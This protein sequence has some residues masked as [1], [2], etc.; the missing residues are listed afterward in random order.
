MASGPSGSASGTVSTLT[1]GGPPV[2][3]SPGIARVRNPIWGVNVR[4][5]LLC[6][7]VL[8]LVSVVISVPPQAL[9]GDPARAI[10][11]RTGTPASR[12]A[13]G[14]QLHLNRPLVVQY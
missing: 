5:L 13:L 8:L 6:A 4:R 11:G 12:A 7:F 3:A 2:T 9:P 14:E 1:P 10:R